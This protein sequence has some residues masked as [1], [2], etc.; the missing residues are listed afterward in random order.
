M[1]KI[2]LAILAVVFVTVLMVDSSRAVMSGDSGMGN[3]GNTGNTGS[4]GGSGNTGNTGSMGGS[5]GNGMPSG[6]GGTMGTIMMPTAQEMFQ[7]G[8][9]TDPIAGTDVSTTMPIGVGSVAMGGNMLTIHTAIGPFSNPMDMYFALY[10]PS[11]SPDILLLHQNGTLEATSNG[12]SP[13]MSGVMSVDQVPFGNI[14]TS[15]LTKGT[16]TLYLMATPSGTN[17]STYYMWTTQFVIQ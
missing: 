1:K 9:I 14:P 11:V 5:G 3:T 13:W 10:A 6:N 16:Y 15:M 8:M 17:M 4:M 12:L 2:G 7:Y